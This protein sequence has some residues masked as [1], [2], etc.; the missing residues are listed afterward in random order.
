[1]SQPWEPLKASSSD[2]LV[3]QDT[4]DLWY[5]AYAA[6]WVTD[7]RADLLQGGSFDGAIERYRAD[8]ARRI[9]DAV[10]EQ[11]KRRT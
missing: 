11:L 5:A 1:M 8:D 7:F 6:A 3:A 9:A 4:A 10:V 2:P